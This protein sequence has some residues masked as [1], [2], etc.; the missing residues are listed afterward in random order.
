MIVWLQWCYQ[1]GLDF[2]FIVW[3]LLSWPPDRLHAEWLQDGGAEVP[4]HW[5]EWA[6]GQVEWG[7]A[8][9][10]EWHDLIAWFKFSFCWRFWLGFGCWVGYPV[11]EVGETRLHDLLLSVLGNC[12]TSCQRETLSLCL[13]SV[14][15]PGRFMAGVRLWAWMGKSTW[16]RHRP[17]LVIRASIFTSRQA[18]WL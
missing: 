2:R 6:G 11:L 1:A 5:P 3:A 10:N 15:I 18:T 7:G 8:S 12:S 14:V 16:L 13:L 17:M 9:I 4:W